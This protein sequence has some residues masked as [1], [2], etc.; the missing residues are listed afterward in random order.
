MKTTLL[1][2]NRFKKI[3]WILIL[4]SI[5]FQLY[6]MIFKKYLITRYVYVPVLFSN[7]L[8]KNFR[9]TFSIH[10]H[11]IDLTVFLTLSILGCL[12]VIFSKEKIEDEL[13]SN[14]R[15]TS[16]IWSVLISYMLFLILTMTIYGTTYLLV[17]I[18]NIY[19]IPLVYLIRFNFLLYKNSFYTRT[20]EQ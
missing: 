6:P 2:H 20:D 7:D 12:L 1:F 18:F 8:F 3:G 16:L 11:D 5:G 14:I 10:P 9:E 4:I 17:C 15:L 19:T 13:V